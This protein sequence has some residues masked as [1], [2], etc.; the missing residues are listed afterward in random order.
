[1]TVHSWT[2]PE[3]SKPSSCTSGS[4]VYSDGEIDLEN[5]LLHVRR[6]KE[7]SPATHPL[8]GNEPY[9]GSSVQVLSRPQ[10]DPA[11]CATPSCR[12]RGSRT[13]GT[14]AVVDGRVAREQEQHKQ[15][16]GGHVRLS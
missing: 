14:D 4:D 12:L 16:C 5:A 6:V 11:Q 3:R 8:T 1:M 15:C 9:G 7:G 10:I 13:F 2:T